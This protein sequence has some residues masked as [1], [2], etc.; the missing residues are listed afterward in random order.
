MSKEHRYKLNITWTGNKGVGTQSYRS[1]DRSHTISFPGKEDILASADPA[2][3]GDSSKYNPEEFLLAAL[4]TCHMLWFLHLCADKGVIVISYSD[5]PSGLMIEASEGGGRF[6]EVML[7]PTVIV[8]EK[9]MLSTLD[10]LHEQAH[11]KCF[12]ANSVNFPVTH[13]GNYSV[14]EI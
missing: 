3:H 9:S 8:T 13:I 14:I 10:E 7:N 1:Y 6:K 12:I 11:R 4:S 5:E 2:F